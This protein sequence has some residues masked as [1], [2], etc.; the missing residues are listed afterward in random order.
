M[1]T[2]YFVRHGQ[3]DWN[4]E[5]R[6]QG[7][8]ESTLTPEGEAQARRV[9]KRV[10]ELGVDAIVASTLR[11]A[12]QSAAILAE[13][14]GLVPRHDDRLVEWDAGDW[15]GRLYADIPTAWPSEWA[16]WTADP[17]TVPSPGGETFADLVTRGR[18]ALDEVLASPAARTAI[19]SH[20]FL[21]RAVLGDL[22]GLGPDVAR[23]HQPN[24][25]FF[26][27]R[28]DAGGWVGERFGPEGPPEP[29]AIP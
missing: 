8:L 9:A 29:L 12:R 26:R 17:W 23:L 20:G 16:A 24:D 1:R 28:E 4:A 25:S 19:V 6:V 7:R 3:T 14:T 13:V 10:A 15:S 21:G 11:R 2:L 27:C 22:L 5:G 18:P